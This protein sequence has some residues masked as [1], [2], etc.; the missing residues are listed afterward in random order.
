MTETPAFRFGM[1]Q[2]VRRREDDRF[3]RGQGRF[4]DDIEH[5]GQ[6]HAAFLRAPHAHAILRSIDAAAAKTAPGVFAVWTATEA[7]AAGLSD[8]R[9]QAPIEQADGSPIA[10]VTTPL[11]A[12]DRVRFVGEPVAMVVAESRAAAEEAAELIEV[13]YLELPSV[14]SA[15]TALS[16]DAPELHEAAPGN[17]A[18]VWEVGDQD[19]VESAF[20]AA[21]HRVSVRVR[22]QRVVVNAIE[23]RACNAR[24]DPDLRRWLIHVA[25]Q[26]SHGMRDLMAEVLGVRPDRLRVVTPD[27]GGGFGMKL[28]IHPEYALVAAAARDLG[29][30]VKWTASRSES[31]LSDAQGRD[32]IAEAEGAFDADGGL[33]AM[34]CRSTSNLGAYYSQYGAA[35]HGTFSAPLIGGFYRLPAAHVGLRCA[36]TN[37]TPTDAYRGAG[38]PEIIFVTESIMDAASRLIGLD[39]AEIRRRNLLKPEDFPRETTTGAL[40]DSGDCPATLEMALQ[41]A[42]Y[43]ERAERKRRSAARG[44]ARGLG[45]AYYM[46]RTG[47][48]PM[49]VARIRVRG[50]GRIEA[51]IGTQSTGQGHE[52]AWS[53]LIAERLGT[54][55]DAI[56]FPP[57][58]SDLLPTGG[59]TGGS[60]SLIM[61]H[62]TFFLAADEV[63]EI[64]RRIAAA[65]LEAA[66]ADIEFSARE[67]GLFRIAGTD[68]T[69]T[70]F[71]A[72]AA[73][74]DALGE[75]AILGRGAVSD[76]LPTFPNGAHIAEVELDPATGL[77]Q[78]LAFTVADDFGRVLNPLLV[79]GQAHGG[80]AQG[81]GQALCEGAAW[82]EESGQP[83]T[84]SFMDYQLPR[85]SDLPMFETVLNDG[86]P[87]PSNPLGVKGAGEAGAVGATPAV[88]FAIRDALRE[89]GA[90][91]AAIEALEPPF[92]PL[93]L[94]EALRA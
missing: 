48:G 8:L 52:T 67:G 59:G 63:I 14:I 18:L 53:Q 39:Q 70:L 28:M 7:A 21:A 49:E 74:Q 62:R 73:A 9:S 47:G 82:D 85:A 43:A 75:P 93:K 12:R 68:R 10:P 44:R 42:G 94:W 51:W 69:M 88:V 92:T 19:A 1:G 58:D 55:F 35:V 32:L 78:L 89:A 2:P 71:D 26:G 66:E 76:R 83:L 84:G 60:R 79:E 36:F 64:G 31:F 41:A 29:R 5:D 61:A 13:E 37:T 24:Y 25:S 4:V 45:V 15:E 81:I 77:V 65:R 86:A 27:V 30:P 17:Q 20:A 50:D 33:L 46:E 22:S 3:L 54:P 90:S 16:P 56:D 40:F 57:G 91:E 34:R 23:P 6:A 80:V 72:A 11:L 38:R 87:T